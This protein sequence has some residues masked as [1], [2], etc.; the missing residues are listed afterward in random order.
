LA[1]SGPLR[2]LGALRLESHQ[3]PPSRQTSVALPHRSVTSALVQRPAEGTVARVVPRP[4]VTQDVLR[5]EGEDEI[6]QSAMSACV[7]KPSRQCW[8]DPRPKGVDSEISQHQAQLWPRFPSCKKNCPQQLEASPL[9]EWA[10]RTRELPPA[11]RRAKGPQAA[12]SS[13]SVG[14]HRTHTEDSNQSMKPDRHEAS[15]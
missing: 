3:P 2:V 1:P 12:P 10:N 9:P 7:T 13:S 8:T 11:E 14:T 4:S 15:S 6:K 5:R